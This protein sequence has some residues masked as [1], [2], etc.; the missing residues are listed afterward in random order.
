MAGILDK[1]NAIVGH[2]QYGDVLPVLEYIPEMNGYIL[3]GGYIGFTFICQ[4]LTG[5]NNDLMNSLDDLYERQFPAD[6]FLQVSLFG[7]PYIKWILERFE[8]IREGRAEG[9]MGELY[10]E[11]GRTTYQYYEEST[12]KPLHP[13]TGL[14][15]RDYEVWVSFKMPLK[16]QQPSKAELTAFRRLYL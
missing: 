16:K 7:S 13:V 11:I 15:V 14:K 8:N 2:N 3:D 9:E 1:H 6:S 10:D 4:P 12:D 5:V